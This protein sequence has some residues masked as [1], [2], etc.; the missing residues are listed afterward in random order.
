MAS[1]FAEL[2]D[3]EFQLAVD[4]E[5]SR[6]LEKILCL[7]P[8]FM[9]IYLLKV[10][11]EK[12]LTLVTHR[13]ASHVCQTLLILSAK[14]IERETKGIPSVIPEEQKEGLEE[15]PT[16]TELIHKIAKTLKGRWSE[17]S[18]NPFASHSLRVLVQLLHGSPLEATGKKSV[19]SKKSKK[20]MESKSGGEFKMIELTGSH[21]VPDSF[22]GLLASISNELVFELSDVVVR[23][24]VLHSNASPL[25]QL[26]LLVS[27]VRGDT[28]TADQ[29]A[30]KLLL[31]VPSEKEIA[32]GA[33]KL[34]NA[35]VLTM[36][37]DSV[38]SHLFE[39]IL[40]AVSSAMYSRIYLVYFRRH[41]MELSLHM[42]SN[43]AVQ[44]LIANVRSSMQLGL[45]LEEIRVDFEKLLRINRI[46]I[47][48][49]VLDGCLATNSCYKEAIKGLAQAYHAETPAQQADFILM[50][51]TSS[52]YQTFKQRSADFKPKYLEQGSFL[53][54]ALLSFPEP[55]NAIVANSL[56][57]QPCDVLLG[58]AKDQVACHVLDKFLLSST[59]SIKAKRKLYRAFEGSLHILATDKFGS[60]ILD[61]LWAIADINTKEAMVAEI[62][63][64]EQLLANNF[65]GKFVLKN[66]RV[67]HFKRKRE[68]WKL[69]EEGGE[70]KKDMFRDILGDEKIANI[71]KPVLPQI[72]KNAVAPES[73][74]ALGVGVPTNDSP[75]EDSPPRPLTPTSSK[76][77]SSKRSKSKD[78][79]LDDI[80]S[81]LAAGGKKRKDDTEKKPKS[82]RKAK[83]DDSE[84]KEL[85]VK[86]SKS[87]K[88][89]KA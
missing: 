47:I 71:Q 89:S 28:D 61:N 80:L 50:V 65:F 8:D 63:P 10:L 68:E 17:F 14:I 39:I 83:R 55:H 37:K 25:L 70:K 2:R 46:G 85:L 12:F 51:L 18:F 7:A 67:E 27:H 62:L 4:H 30:D 19:R 49:S 86:S 35:F 57:G 32:L 56:L 3:K 59:I 36:L 41:V 9:K 66:F 16:M 20:Y 29:F 79:G 6:V 1:A 31:G 26:M 76:E 87:K 42:I 78:S 24:S 5:C 84:L 52:D 23:S 74:A 15:L 33:D 81:A 69:G 75:D 73:L 40:K 34:R 82:E 64:H 38:G 77:K 21:L 53:L 44:A 11:S 54:Q 72:L 43:Y 22:Q 58:L 88:K 60:R 13:F 48:R 45:I